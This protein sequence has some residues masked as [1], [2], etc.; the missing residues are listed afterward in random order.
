MCAV[1]MVYDYGKRMS[2]DWWDMDKYHEYKRLLEGAKRF[3]EKTN[4]PHCEDENKAE[5]LQKIM[6]RLDIIEKKLDAKAE[7]AASI[8]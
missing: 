6:D 7:N 1:S 2:Y 5:F 8:R 4:Q 3:D